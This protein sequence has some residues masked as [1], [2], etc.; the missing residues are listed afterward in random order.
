MALA[1]QAGFTAR[2]PS[3][4]LPARSQKLLDSIEAIRTQAVDKLKVQST[5]TFFINGTATAGAMSIEEMAK[6][7]EPLLKSVTT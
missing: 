6:Q 1:K 5:P 4:C 3:Q 2:R 7:I